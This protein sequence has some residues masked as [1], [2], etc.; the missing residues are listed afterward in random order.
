MMDRRADP[1][2]QFTK[3]ELM[4]DSLRTIEAANLERSAHTVI[5]ENESRQ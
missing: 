3:G 4:G 2:Q 5:L 1:S